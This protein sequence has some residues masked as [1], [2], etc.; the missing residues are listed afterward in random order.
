[1]GQTPAWDHKAKVV[2]FR[3]TPESG[4]SAGRCFVRANSGRQRCSSDRFGTPA[5]FTGDAIQR[6]GIWIF[7]RRCFRSLSFCNLRFGRWRLGWSLFG[8]LLLLLLLLL[9]VRWLLNLVSLHFRQP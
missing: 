5:E 1:M 4:L 8:G 9:L 6:S 2:I 3:F 7:G